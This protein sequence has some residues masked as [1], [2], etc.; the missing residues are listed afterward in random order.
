MSKGRNPKAEGATHKRRRVKLIDE[1]D[2]RCGV[3]G[4][5][6]DTRDAM[7]EIDLGP[8]LVSHRR[9]FFLYRHAKKCKGPILNEVFRL[10][11]DE[12]EECNDGNAT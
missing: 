1:Q 11:N 9:C 6:M 10:V 5:E 2:R 3:C 12:Y 7:Y 4:I 8:G